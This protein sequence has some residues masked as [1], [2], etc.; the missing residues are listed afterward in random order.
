M[1][2]TY[3]P[4]HHCC[5]FL[6]KCHKIPREAKERVTQTFCLLNTILTNCWWEPKNTQKNKNLIFFFFL[7]EWYIKEQA[8]HKKPAKWMS[9]FT[10]DCRLS[11]LR[12][13]LHYVKKIKKCVLVFP[14]RPLSELSARLCIC[15]ISVTEFTCWVLTILSCCSEWEN[16]KRAVWRGP[17]RQWFVRCI[18]EY[19]SS[20]YSSVS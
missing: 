14:V 10:Q 17:I 6:L 12:S 1:H 3:P 7:K 20:V 15:P 19:S 16:G 8:Y 9:A 13:N 2:L 18:S 4:S 11:G 5:H